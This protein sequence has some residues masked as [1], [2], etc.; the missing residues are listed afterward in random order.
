[1]IDYY[2]RANTEAA[3]AN[4]F[5]AAGIT[6]P[7]VDGQIFDGTV[8]DCNGIRLDLGWIGPVTRIVDGEPVTD[9]R[10]HANLRVAGELPP[11]VLAELP[12]LDPPPAV[13][14]RVWA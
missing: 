3:M 1:M 11:D 9:S 4:A 7:T 5:L 12:I 13:P 10:F 8:L 6:I 2:L 14:M